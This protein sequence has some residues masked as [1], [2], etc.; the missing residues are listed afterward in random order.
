MYARQAQHLNVRAAYGFTVPSPTTSGMRRPEWLPTIWLWIWR[1]NQPSFVVR[2]FIGYRWTYSALGFGPS[3]KIARFHSADQVRERHGHLSQC[4]QS[5]C[6]S[7]H[8][9]SI[10]ATK[11]IKRVLGETYSVDG[12]AKIPFFNFQTCT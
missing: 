11:Q 2:P 6:K 9:D 12:W 7:T 8:W 1:R 4:L 3:I 10:F 5:A